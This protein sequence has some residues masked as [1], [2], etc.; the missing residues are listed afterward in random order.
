MTRSY[1]M[2]IDLGTSSVRAVLFDP[3]GNPTLIRQK[4]IPLLTEGQ[5]TAELDPDTVYRRLIEVVRE[6]MESLGPK[7]KDLRG[8]GFSTQLHS[9]VAVDKENRPLTRAITWADNRAHRQADR[10]EREQ[11][12]RKLYGITGCRVQHPL[13]PLSKIL[14]LQEEKPDLFAQ[15]A[16]FMTLK[17]Y[18]LQKMFGVCII[19]HTDASATG[20]FNIHTFTWEPSIVQG[21]LRIDADRLPEPVE[22]TAPLPPL[23]PKVQKE[24]GLQDSVLI[25]AGSG[26]GILAN[27]GS[28]IFD[29]TAMTSTIGTSGALRTTVSRPL[30]DDEQRTWCYCLTRDRWVAGGAINNGGLVLRWLRDEFR[31][32]FQK[33]AKAQKANNVYALF[34]SFAD[35]LPAGSDG[36]FFLPLLTGERSPHWNS[37]TRGVLF[38]LDLR[39]G[40]RHLVKAA[41]EGIM[42]QMHSVYQA[43]ASINTNARQIR[44]GGGY[45]KSAVWLQIQ[46]DMFQKPIAISTVSEASSLGAAYLAM[47]ADGTVSELGEELPA[48]SFSKSFHPNPKHEKIYQEGYERYLDLYDRLYR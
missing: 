4:E 44:A 40:R 12:C 36:L 38:G 32:T 30:L 9:L 19:D 8:I 20:L 46:A 17:S 43:L 28:G 15:T 27:V 31:E 25:V 6:C 24:L 3:E 21:I 7:A 11:D 39:H 1:Y 18:L 34:D 37:R 13:Y 33:D 48:M 47:L 45:A 2:G 22:C 16:C 14:W 23:L 42:Y 29:D 5:D 26:D 10:I 35:A 41:M